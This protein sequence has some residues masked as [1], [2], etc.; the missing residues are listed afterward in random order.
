MPHLL[1]PW[2]LSGLRQPS[3]QSWSHDGDQ[4]L[5]GLHTSLFINV[6]QEKEGASP[7]FSWMKRKLHPIESLDQIGNLP[8]GSPRKAWF[9]SVLSPLNDQGGGRVNYSVAYNVLHDAFA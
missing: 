2:R 6:Q 7:W 1:A 3:S 9:E 5:L 4:E 8:A